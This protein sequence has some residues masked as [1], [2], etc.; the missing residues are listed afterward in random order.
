MRDVIG[1][2]R[3]PGPLDRKQSLLK[4]IKKVK[5]VTKYD[6]WRLLFIYAKNSPKC[7]KCHEEIPKTEQ[8][9]SKSRFRIEVKLGRSYKPEIL[10]L[11]NG[12]KSCFWNIQTVKTRDFGCFPLFCG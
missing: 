11:Q 3:V 9:Y 10:R 7:S 2:L 5:K 4:I 8:S 6:F 12:H 1:W